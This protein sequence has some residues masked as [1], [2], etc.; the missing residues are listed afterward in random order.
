MK[1]TSVNPTDWGLAYSMDQGELIEGLSRTLHC[2]GQV[3]VEAEPTSEMGI[4][5]LHPGDVRSQMQVALA[6]IDAILAKA[7][8]T[9]ANILSLR[10]FTTDMDGFLANYDV[11]AE[12]ITEAGAPTSVFDWSRPSCR[13]RP[14]R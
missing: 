9:R 14:G 2:S 5:I 1:R 13:S 12:W 8:M 11:Y 3:S 7:G 10:F 4:K 6:N